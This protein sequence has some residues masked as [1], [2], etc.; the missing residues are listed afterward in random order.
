MRL[1]IALCTVPTTLGLALA[2]SLAWSDATDCAAPVEKVAG[3]SDQRWTK[4]TVELPT[5]QTL[6]P[7]GSGSD[8]A[9]GQCLICHSAGMVLSQPPL[10]QDEWVGEINKMRNAF[11]APL[12]ADQVE[13][14]AKYLVSINGG[15]SRGGR[16][17][18]DGQGG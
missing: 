1:S 3:V 2:T 6:F 16:T 4:V 9:T 18:V 14:L 17:A 13:V 10:T 7:P 11:G 12:P 5:S 15:K 8:I